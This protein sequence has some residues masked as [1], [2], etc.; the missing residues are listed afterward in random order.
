MSGVRMGY[1]E[2]KSSEGWR[3]MLGQGGNLE[4]GYGREEGGVGGTFPPP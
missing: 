3:T 1:A 4:F 2:I